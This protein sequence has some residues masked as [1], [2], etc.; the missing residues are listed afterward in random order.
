MRPVLLEMEG[1]ASFRERAVVDFEEA[2]YFAI[3]GPTGSGKSTL[4]DAMTFALFGSAPRWGRKNAVSMALS[5]HGN[6][7]VVRLVFELAGHRYVVARE[8]RRTGASISAKNQRLERLPSLH[9]R[10]EVDEVTVSLA[11]DSKVTEAVEELLGLNFE[12]FRQCVVLPQ[13][14]F[15]EF[16]HSTPSNRQQ[17]LLRLIGAERYELIRGEANQRAQ[18]AADRVE[19]LNREIGE[20]GDATEQAQHQAQLRHEQVSEVVGQVREAL[21]GL[22]QAQ[23][24]LAGAEAE[25]QRLAA[26]RERLAAIVVPAGVSEIDR[27]VSAAQEAAGAAAA[28]ESQAEEADTAARER[29]S[30]A[31]ARGPLEQTLNDHAELERLGTQRPQLAEAEHEARK[32]H[33]TSGQ[34]VTTAEL[35]QSQAQTAAER[36]G[37]AAD[38]ARR[39]VSDLDAQH[40]LLTRTTLPPG[41]DELDRDLAGAQATLDA[42]AGALADA[43]KADEAATE[44]LAAGPPRGPLERARQTLEELAQITGRLSGLTARAEAVRA[45]SLEAASAVDARAGAV[46]AARQQ[47]DQVQL[48]HAAAGLREHL[49][50]GDDCPVCAQPVAALPGGPVRKANSHRGE[51]AGQTPELAAADAALAEAE[52]QLEL[53]RTAQHQAGRDE[54]AAQTRLDTTRKREEELRA[55]LPR[56]C[57]DLAT[58]DRLLGELEALEAARRQAVQQVRQARVRADEARREAEQLTAAQTRIRSS[59]DR[60]RDPLVAFGAPAVGDL[61]LAEAWRRLTGWA[62]GQAVTTGT[63]LAE[64]RHDLAEAETEQQRAATELEQTQTTLREAR[65]AQSSA[66]AAAERARERVERAEQQIR[67]LTQSLAVAVPPREARERIELVDALEAA[68]RQADEAL[69]QARQERERARR[70]LSMLDDQLSGGWALLRRTRDK[71]V[72]LGA[73][74]LTADG[75]LDGWSALTTWSSGAADERE[76]RLGAARL[77]TTARRDE[78]DRARSALVG[79]LTRAEVEVPAADLAGTALAVV[80]GE[81]AQA[82][83]A[84]ERIRERR[85]RAAQ[86]LADREQQER[87]AQVARMLGDLLRSDRFPRWLATAA[88]ESLVTEASD[89]LLRLSNGQFD[90]DHDDKGELVVVD[91]TDADARRS[92]K[93]LSGG[94]TFQASLAMA[95]ALSSQMSQLSSAGGARLDSIFLDEGFGT[96]DPDTLETVAGT[97]ENLARGER[98][99]G[100]ITHVPALA[101]RVPVRFNVRRDART[102]RVERQ[103]L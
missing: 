77:A 58:A 51:E 4:V 38:E 24:A 9:S 22:A 46:A 71:V 47:R 62:A 82:R 101:D 6:R 44:A 93:T 57:P 55:A 27:A 85:Q 37:R 21:P 50:L 68:V 60:A 73:P 15:A 53:A 86:V 19:H 76:T 64:A 79:L 32:L 66:L 81:Q 69:R 18:K 87:E 65:R 34:Q 102:S 103:N 80:T 83:A 97:L 30:A 89:T 26:E 88:L 67:Q 70:R 14:A 100:V 92:V 16:L 10:G 72:Q 63:E 75:L 96:L 33:E 56:A 41:L 1:F 7:A 78:A 5:P 31:P 29:L 54:S 12:Q 20:L 90:L 3:V 91:H 13:N 45:A 48:R 95:L 84:L 61:S 11:A 35:R 42:A 36:A 8:V 74:E 17:I 39:R 40:Q 28:V 2:D 49:V 23:Q 52:R 59:L 94:E 25:E 43:E 99:V 98:M